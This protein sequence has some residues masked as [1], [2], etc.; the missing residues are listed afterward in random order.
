V[1]VAVTGGRGFVGRHVLAELATR[2]VDVVSTRTPGGPQDDPASS[3]IRWVTLDIGYPPEKCFAALGEPDVLIHLAWSGLPNYRSLHH[4]ESELPAQYRFLAG[5]IRDG[6]PSLLGVGTCFEYGFQ[7]GPLAADFETRPTN[8]YGY[9][10]DALRKQLQLLKTMEPFSFTWA[11]LFYMYGEGQP[12]TSLLPK[13]KEA[14]ALERRTFEMSGGEQLRD[15]LPVGEV[16]RR[17][18]DLAL[19]LRD[20]GPINICS[21][22]PVSV[23]RLVEGWIREHGWKIEL[24]LG[25]YPYPDYEPMAFWG[26]PDDRL[27]PTGS[28]S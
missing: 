24:E 10:K 9:A 26:V 8:P 19:E 2:P 20:G 27:L 7:S 17:L 28:H 13:L 11:R 22:K 1:K 3:P 4:F 6:L 14:V 5:L 18:V 21:G 16:A 23:R 25:R 15:Y 12:E